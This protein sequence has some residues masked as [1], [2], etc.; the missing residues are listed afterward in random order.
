LF[1][2]QLLFFLQFSEIMSQPQPMIAVDKQALKFSG[3]VGASSIPSQSLLMTLHAGGSLLG[4]MVS[5]DADWVTVAPTDGMLPSSLKVCVSADGLSEGMYTALI[6]ITAPGAVSKTVPV[7]LVLQP[8]PRPFLQTDLQYISFEVTGSAPA[9]AK[10]AVSAPLLADSSSLTVFSRS[11]MPWFSVKPSLGRISGSAGSAQFEVS[12]D[13]SNLSPAIYFGT[14][15]S[16]DTSNVAAATTLTVQLTVFPI[17]VMAVDKQSLKFKTVLG[18]GSVPHQTLTIRDQNS[19]RPLPW[20][21]TTDASWLM[22]SPTSG[23]ASTALDV[24][25]A[26]DGLLA[27]I[28]T[29]AINISSTIAG[30]LPK[31]VPVTIVVSD[32]INLVVPILSVDQSAIVFETTQGQNPATQQV[33]VTLSNVSAESSVTVYAGDNSSFLT[34]TPALQVSTA[35]PAIFTLSIDATGLA[36]DVYFSSVTFSDSSKT[37]EPKT[38]SVKLIVGLAPA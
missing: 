37:A 30:V 16:S 7:T 22:L 34:V 31:L 29:T 4:V 35:V 10:L 1:F 21:A 15:T 17:P 2:L 18:G 33:S 20:N 19:A 27:G 8:F 14:L 24:S 3:T 6:V 36:P 23:D 26:P 9:P 13:A 12:V 28:F 38:V 11:N 5:V 32:G 25:V